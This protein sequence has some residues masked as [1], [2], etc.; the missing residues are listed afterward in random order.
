MN[1]AQAKAI[2]AVTLADSE[3]GAVD[4][5]RGTA[6]GL[7][8]S[9]VISRP[10]MPAPPGTPLAMPELTP[11]LA[12]GAPKRVQ[13]TREPA[14]PALVAARRTGLRRWQVDLDQN[15]R[16]VAVNLGDGTVMSSL[17]LGSPKR[18]AAPEPSMS[19]PRPD[20]VNAAS[21]A[22]GVM[23]FA[24]V[25]NGLNGFGKPWTRGRYALTVI[26]FDWVSNTVMV[27][28]SGGGKV[29]TQSAAAKPFPPLLARRDEVP[30]AH[31][32]IDFRLPPSA[33]PGGPQQVQVALGLPAGRV[34]L[35]AAEMPGASLL[36]GSVLLLR[37]D[38][39]QP[40]RAD[41]AIPVRTPP[42]DGR[43]QVLF[44]FD[45]KA[46]LPNALPRGSYQCYLVFGDTV[47][48]PRTLTVD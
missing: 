20:A 32:G 26:E 8:L 16:I 17:L 44:S 37:L 23:P 9:A 39:Q 12:L 3:Y 22:T 40:L 1:E 33:E 36:V 15:L 28:M 18:Q 38:A 21:V 10:L 7:A 42:A 5:E 25:L 6:L 48:G 46:A 2:E 14:L 30:A 29:A 27:E 45:I 24:N 31:E 35:A 19:Q 41:L 11:V 13:L 43:V 34:V 4:A 47:A